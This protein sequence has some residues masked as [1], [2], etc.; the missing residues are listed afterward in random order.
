MVKNKYIFLCWFFLDTGCYEL[1]KPS[2]TIAVQTKST[3]TQVT[4]IQTSTGKTKS[5]A[6]AGKASSNV[7]NRHGDM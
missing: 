5:I 2:T 1:V 4:H 7:S 6:I 3:T